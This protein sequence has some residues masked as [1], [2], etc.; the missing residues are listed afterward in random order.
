[1]T[2]FL[3]KAFLR[4][5]EHTDICKNDKSVSRIILLILSIYDTI[6]EKSEPGKVI[7]P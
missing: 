7:V 3:Y 4:Q 1:M 5:T 2:I 6:S